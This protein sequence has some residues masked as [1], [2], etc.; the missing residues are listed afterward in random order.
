M[1]NVSDIRN[2]ES[3]ACDISRPPRVGLD[4]ITCRTEGLCEMGS[5][6][7]A[8]PGYKHTPGRF[9]FSTFTSRI[10][11]AEQG[12]VSLGSF[13]RICQVPGGR[14]SFFRCSNSSIA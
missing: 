10:R 9:H 11:R 14:S 12:E 3:T 2:I 5:Y 4:P 6:K 1:E 13:F 8:G 7:P